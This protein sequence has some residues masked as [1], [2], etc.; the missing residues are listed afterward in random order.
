MSEVIPI[1]QA[2]AS[3][4]A[5][6]DRAQLEPVLLER[7]GTV[8]A[9]LVSPEFHARAIASLEEAADVAAFDQALRGGGPAL[10]WNQAKAD[11]GWA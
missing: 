1:S 7:H 8:E 2:R 9:V 10:P 6:I 4:R 5:V 3:L 11:L